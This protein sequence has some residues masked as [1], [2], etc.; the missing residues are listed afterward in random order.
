MRLGL[1]LICFLLLG[2]ETT[3]P[4]LE[5]GVGYQI[6]SNTDWLL[7]TNRDYQCRNPQFHGEVGLETEDGWT[8]GYYHQS[9]LFCGGPFNNRAETYM[10]AIRITKKF[11][12]Q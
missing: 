8:L 3:E 7:R 4:Y 5:L 12:G 11:G 9:W 1:V 10:D 6:D 2:C